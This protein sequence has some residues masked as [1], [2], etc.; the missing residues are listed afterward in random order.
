LFFN[1]FQVYTQR[2]LR[3]REPVHAAGA[4]EEAKVFAN[5][6]SA[7]LRLLSAA[8]K[9][10]LVTPGLDE[11]PSFGKS[12]RKVSSQLQES[13]A[14]LKK[15]GADYAKNAKAHQAAVELAERGES[16]EVQA[17]KQ[18]LKETV[19]ADE[20]AQEEQPQRL[21]WITRKVEGLRSDLNH[22]VSASAPKKPRK[23]GTALLSNVWPRPPKDA[24]KAEV[25]FLMKG[26]RMKVTAKQQQ[27]ETGTHGSLR[28]K[29]SIAGEA[30]QG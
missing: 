30:D 5:K 13:A 29:T 25:G 9:Q 28:S 10:V 22:L 18:K 8:A 11:E 15:W 14:I 1:F 4:G 3:S 17:L 24:P 20:K 2:Q 6:A 12:L 16:L 26:T 19:D 23:A 21:E 27:K 7:R